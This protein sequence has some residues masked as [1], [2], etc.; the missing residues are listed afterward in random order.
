[1]LSV[2]GFLVVTYK[3]ASLLNLKKFSLTKLCFHIKL[4]YINFWIKRLLLN[5]WLDSKLKVF[6]FDFIVTIQFIMNFDKLSLEKYIYWISNEERKIIK[7]I[8]YMNKGLNLKPKRFNIFVFSSLIL[9]FV[10]II[11][12][13]IIVI[14]ICYF[15]LYFSFENFILVIFIVK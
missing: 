11:R 8:F 4:Y 5:Y 7:K 14:N 2:Y 3:T 1:V 6:D 9:T 12:S 13:I 10:L 15:E